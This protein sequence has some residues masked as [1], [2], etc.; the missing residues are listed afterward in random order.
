MIKMYKSELVVQKIP[1]NPGLVRKTVQITAPEVI[2]QYFS[3]MLINLICLN[4]VLSS[5]I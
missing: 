5:I 1:G 4:S 3:I 2:D